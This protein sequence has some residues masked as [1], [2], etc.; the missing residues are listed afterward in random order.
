MKI[1]GINPSHNSTAALLID[2]KI[3]SCISEERITR[4][5]NE[6]GN[7]ILSIKYLLKEHN[8]KPS[9]IDYIAVAMRNPTA[10]IHY[11][12]EK[13]GHPKKSRFINLTILFHVTIRPIIDKLMQRF[14]W[15]GKVYQ[16]IYRLTYV[17]IMWSLL[18]PAVYRE[19][20]GLGFEKKQIVFVDHHETHAMSAYCNMPDRQKGDVLVLTAD[21]EGDGLCA[22]VSIINEDKIKKLSN[23]M[24]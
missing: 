9:D 2:G 22:S 5:K 8:L 20:K 19:F 12:E 4:F 24:R 21:G 23:L 6:T 14:P 15:F 1:I 3:V 10:Y 13:G 17:P 18:R 16:S 7:P 11:R